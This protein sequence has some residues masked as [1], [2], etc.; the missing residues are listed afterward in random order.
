MCVSRSQLCQAAN[1]LNT[2][3]MFCSGVVLIASLFLRKLQLP[4]QNVCL[5]PVACICKCLIF[6]HCILLFTCNGVEGISVLVAHPVSTPRGKLMMPPADRIHSDPGQGARKVP[7]DIADLNF[8]AV[9]PALRMNVEG[10]SAATRS[11]SMERILEVG[12]GGQCTHRGRPHK[13]I[14]G[15]CSPSTTVVSAEPFLHQTR[16][17]QCL[18]EEMETF[19]LRS[20]FLR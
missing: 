15:L 4:L 6:L 19:R 18:L 10:L 14:T 16:S 13:P 1:F 9:G 8:Q 2:P 17:L 5:F 7:S 11:I 20:V 12:L 3:H